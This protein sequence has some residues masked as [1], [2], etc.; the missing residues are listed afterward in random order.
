MLMSCRTPLA[1]TACY[2]TQP[3]DLGVATRISLAGDEYLGLKPC[4]AAPN[5]FCSTMSVEEDPD[6]SIPAWTW[7][8]T[9]SVSISSDNS[10][11]VSDSKLT[12]MAA[13]E[14]LYQV[15]QS[16]PPGQGG[17]DGGGCQLQ[18]YDA[19][20]GYIYIIY[21]ALK[22]GYYD[23]V[24]FAYIR[25]TNGKDSSSRQIQVRSSSRV[26]YLDFGVNAKRLNW[27]AKELRKKGWDA[28]GVDYATHRVYALENQR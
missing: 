12:M 18:K 4:G 8:E 16:Y 25:P 9:L 15:L 2:Q 22:N 13:F 23:D 3:K 26:G 7:P 24:E 6:H 19:S 5:C 10:T 17:V 20:A 27:I 11:G 21:E 28:P 14:Q 1:I